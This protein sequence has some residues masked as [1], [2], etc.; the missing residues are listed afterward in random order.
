MDWI[1]LVQDRDTW[2]VLVN[3]IMN[4]WV[5]YNAGDF[6]TSVESVSISESTLFHGVR[7][8]VI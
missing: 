2:R 4:L 7:W 6:L 3:V 8:L 1:T 5:L